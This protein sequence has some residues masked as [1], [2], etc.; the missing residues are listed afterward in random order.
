MVNEGK[1]MEMS[2]DLQS[3]L[4]LVV[5]TFGIRGYGRYFNVLPW[6]LTRFNYRGG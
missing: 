1:G 3:L 5:I 6:P 4:V 2:V